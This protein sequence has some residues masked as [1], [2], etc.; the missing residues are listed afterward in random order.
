MNTKNKSSTLSSIEAGL[1]VIHQQQGRAKIQ[2]RAASSSEKS[3]PK[4]RDDLPIGRKRLGRGLSSLLG[5]APVA[6]ADDL[7]QREVPIEL[8]SP[9]SGQAR[10]HFD[11]ETLKELSISI[12]NHGLVQPLILRPHPEHA[13]EYEIIAG[14]RRWRAAQLAGL[15]R[16]P[17]VVRDFSD[18]MALEV[19]L[20]EN[21][22]RSDL[23]P[24]EEAEALHRLLTTFGYNQG[25]L[26]ETLGKSRSHIANIL[27]L[28]ALPPKI[29]EALNE[30]K[31]SMSHARALLTAPDAQALADQVIAQGLSVRQTEDLAAR[32][33][34]GTQEAQASASPRTTSQDS[35]NILALERE[36]SSHLGLGVRLKHRGDSGGAMTIRYRDLDQLDHLLARLRR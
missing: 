30:G 16:V 34:E 27:R 32:R 25:D 1:R 21:V 4:E 6:L 28:R 19:G 36:I 23:L 17:A 7:G 31:L 13:G 20:V 14:E 26:T 24:L 29:K 5:E 8:I 22:Q 18:R 11:P 3:P 10:R 33:R 35:A 9:G 2:D 12:R 15:S